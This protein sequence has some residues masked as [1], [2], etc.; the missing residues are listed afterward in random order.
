[1][2]F[3]PH[4]VR[5]SI[6]FYFNFTLTMDRSPGFGSILTYFRPIKTRFRYGF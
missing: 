3:K 4:P 1:M 2:R 6:E 5:A